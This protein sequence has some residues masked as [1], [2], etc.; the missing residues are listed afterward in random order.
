MHYGTMM[1]TSQFGV[2]GQRS[3]SQWNKVCW[4]QHFVGFV[5]RCLEKLV[6]FSPKLHQKC[7]MWQRWMC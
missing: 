5:T 2:K 6:R 4:K 3:R 1:N 7:I